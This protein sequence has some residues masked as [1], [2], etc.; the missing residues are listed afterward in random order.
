MLKK[1]FVLILCVKVMIGMY[2]DVCIFDLFGNGL[3]S[4]DEL[5]RGG[6]A[7]GEI[8]F[9]SGGVMVF[10]YVDILLGVLICGVVIND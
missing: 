3:L 9:E 5:S 6:Y 4:L 1:L 7:Y 8:L 10:E 2:L